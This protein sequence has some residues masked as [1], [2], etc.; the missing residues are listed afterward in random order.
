M[1]QLNLITKNRTVNGEQVIT[2]R[3]RTYSTVGTRAL[4]AR[5]AQSSNIKDTDVTQAVHAIKD[6]ILYFVLNGHHVNL[7]RLGIFGMSA[8]IASCAQASQCSV[9]LVKRLKISYNPSAEIKEKIAN[10]QFK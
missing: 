10:I 1:G 7:G 2:T 5:I 8:N 6:A 3:K 4:V 9:D